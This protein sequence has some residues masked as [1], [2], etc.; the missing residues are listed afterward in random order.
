M[1]DKDGRD[2]RAASGNAAGD[3]LLECGSVV[4][5]HGISGTLKID[6]WCDS[7]EIFASLSRLYILKDGGFEPVRVQ[8][9]SV[10]KRNVLT[11]LEGIDDPEKAESMRGTV[12]YASRDDIPREQ[13]S[14]FI[15]D[16]IG[17]RVIDARTGVEYGRIRDVFNAG[18]SD[19]YTVATPSGDRMFPA[20]SE[21]VE[22]IE[23]PG[24]VYVLPI[25]GMFD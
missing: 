14:Y 24:G 23:I 6:P 18:A 11:K 1:K 10:Q 22:R 20:V 5:V 13:G 7:P 2:A 3:G 9:S 16:L 8:K 21:F 15:A 19:I 25:E 12:L 17:L 4:G